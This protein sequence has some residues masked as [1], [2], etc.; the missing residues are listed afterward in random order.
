MVEIKILKNKMDLIKFNTISIVFFVTLNCLHT[1]FIIDNPHIIESNPI[2]KTLISINPIISVI[3]SILLPVIFIYLVMRYINKLYALSLS[4]IFFGFT[5]FD[6][7]SH[8]L[9]MMN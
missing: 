4:G 1:Y 2:N 9:I 5:F 3:Y 7:F 8:I 6:F